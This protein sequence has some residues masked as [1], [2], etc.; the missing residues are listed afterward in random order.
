[1]KLLEAVLGRAPEPWIEHAVA[2]AG[3]RS[4]VLIVRHLQAR[5]DLGRAEDLVRRYLDVA[6]GLARED[7]ALE[8]AAFLCLAEIAL[9][10]EDNDR[11]YDCADK[12]LHVALVRNDSD[13]RA[14]SLLS[15]ARASKGQTRYLE[16]EQRAREALDLF[17]SAGEVAKIS[18]CLRVLA[19]ILLAQRDGLMRLNE[20]VRA[21][22]RA[23]GE[24]ALEMAETCGD[25]DG[26]IESLLILARIAIDARK[27]NRLRELALQA[28]SL[29]ESTAA[30]DLRAEAYFTM[31]VSLSRR[32]DRDQAVQW[33]QRALAILEH[34][35]P[36]SALKSVRRFLADEVKR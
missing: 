22:A 27:H 36:P 11:A 6:G 17:E 15:L 33:A 14:A 4:A 24:R 21:E 28:A 3:L 2:V 31:A 5:D 26:R 23:L 25:V 13:G 35:G 30:L 16:A 34:I 1:L 19:S 18:T 20:A 7:A 10:R 29:A 8:V 9:S 32:N 12:A